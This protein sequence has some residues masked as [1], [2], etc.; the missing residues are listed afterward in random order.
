MANLNRVFLIGNLT[1]DPELRYVSSGTAVATFGMA[2]NRP[3]TT[4]SGEK[5]E[6]TCFVRIVVWGRQA[7]TCSQYLNK[8]SLVF[9]EGRLVYRTWESE[10]QKRSALE[11]RAD[12]VQFLGRTGGR[13]DGSGSDSAG[14]DY[15][16]A[17]VE[18]E[19]SYS[20][21]PDDGWK[22]GGD[23]VPF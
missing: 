5:R 13:E 14:A 20:E 3:Y 10:G 22:S 6:D 15:S 16:H 8:G 18:T 11:V 12:R 1:R 19:A 21:A 23:D 9:V 17:P 4:Q 7:E 2:I